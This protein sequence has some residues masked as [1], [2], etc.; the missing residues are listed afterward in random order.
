MMNQAET[1][2]KQKHGPY[3]SSKKA[4]VQFVLFL[5]VCVCEVMC[6]T[7]S[8]HVWMERERRKQRKTRN[9]TIMCGKCIRIDANER[10]TKN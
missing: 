5:C 7:C 8:S 2:K 3:E 4:D 10:K 6:G 9:K 1:K